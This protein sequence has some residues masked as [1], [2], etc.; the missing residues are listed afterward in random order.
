MLELGS[1]E[2]QRLL[3]E[4]LIFVHVAFDDTDDACES[5]RSLRAQGAEPR[6]DA[7]LISPKIRGIVADC[8]R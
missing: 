6:L 7:D 3:L 4:H 5:V 1:A 8:P 2:Q